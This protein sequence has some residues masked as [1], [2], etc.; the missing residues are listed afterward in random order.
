[1]SLTKKTV[2]I[3]LSVLL[4]LFL[5]LYIISDITIY[6]GFETLEKDD[7]ARNLLRAE[8]AIDAKLLNLESTTEDWSSWD[9]AFRYAHGLNPEFIPLNMMDHTFTITQWNLIMIFNDQSQPLFAK[10][11]DFVNNQ[12]VPV[13]QELKESKFNEIILN[14]IREGNTQSGFLLTS[15]YPLLVVCKPV[16]DSFGNGPPAGVFVTGIFLDSNLITE[17]S[18]ITHLS[19]AFERFNNPYSPD[20]FKT[21]EHLLSP[22]ES[23]LIKPL[24]QNRIGGYHALQDIYGDPFLILRVDLA[25]DIHLK[26]VTT[27]AFFHIF[28][29][30]ACIIFFII[31]INIL[32]RMVLSRL[33]ILDRTVQDITKTGDKSKRLVVAG[34]D[35]LF[36]LSSNINSMLDSLEQADRK[37]FALYEQEKKQREELEKEAK[38][39]SQFIDVLAHELRTPL[40]PIVVS[41]ELVR[42]MLSKA[43]E[44]IQYKLINN[45]CSSTDSLRSRLEELLDLARYERGAFILN[46]QLIETRDFLEIVAVRYKPAL[47]QKHQQLLVEVQKDLPRIMADPS[48]LEQVLINLLS[49]ASKYSP[50]NSTITLR[51]AI[52]EDNLLVEIQDQGIGVPPEEQNQLFMP[53]H[54]AQQDRQSYPGIGLGLA[55]CSQI[56]Q[57]HG[58][59]IWLESERGKG[60]SFKFTI[61]VNGIDPGE[62]DGNSNIHE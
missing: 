23:N 18:K 20:D 4:P 40:T 49:N 28:L 53:Y 5:I 22:S 11:Y 51:A 26:A 27:V 42:D 41:V 50:E 39:R 21:V 44:S 31:F 6:N 62:R 15:E 54:R 56:I 36:R 59:K 34:K 32:K 46:K 30:L 17:F 37:I 2:Y 48:R 12:E 57:A 58:G 8:D 52:K 43:P 29:F 1:M 33:I 13:S 35:E 10:A 14:V 9:D 3:I 16:L 45:A 7:V 19:L 47:D 61:P 55:V 60:S 25:R 38:A 24:E